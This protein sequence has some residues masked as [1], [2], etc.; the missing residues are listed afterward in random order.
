VIAAAQARG[1]PEDYI[2]ELRGWLN[3]A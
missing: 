1:F 2:E 3:R